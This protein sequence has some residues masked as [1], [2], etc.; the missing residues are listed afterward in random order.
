MPSSGQVSRNVGG[1]RGQLGP[2]PRGERQARPHI[3]LVLVQA[4][5]HERDL[6]RP[7]HL[8]AFGV[9][10]PERLTAR[11]CPLLRSHHDQAPSRT[12]GQA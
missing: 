7:N 11:R 6:Q 12:L 10:R 1:E 8:L 4:A 3:K 5:V 2:G 9:T